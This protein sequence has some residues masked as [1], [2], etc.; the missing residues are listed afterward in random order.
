[1]QRVEVNCISSQWLKV[2]HGVPQGSI[3]G[4]LLFLIYINDLP[5]HCKH[6]QVLLFADDTNLTFLN[7]SCE[8]VQREIDNVKH[9]LDANKLCLNINKTIQLNL[10]S[11]ENRF[12][13]D[14]K[15]ISIEPVCKYLGILV[16]FKFSFVSHLSVL[17]SRLSKQCGIIS[18]LR[19]YSPRNQ[20][21]DYYKTNVSS[22]IQYGILVYGCSSYS[23]LLPI[24]NLLKKI[25]RLIYFRKKSDSAN[26][27]FVKNNL[28]NIYQLHIYELLKLVLKSLSGLHRESYLNSLFSFSPSRPTRSASKTL[29]MEPSCKR[30]IEKRSVKFRASKLFNTLSK[31]D[32]LPYNIIGSNEKVI[33]SFYHKFKDTFLV[34]NDDIVKYIFE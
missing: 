5:L 26:D 22:I 8:E 31:A 16:D 6:A 1:M 32:V 23:N 34:N 20:L 19:H 7:K 33:K 4:P 2:Q 14:N 17:K 13:I 28:L 27:I 15:Y 30:M 12:D 25:L 24:Y 29:L 11:S 18:K 9:W 3:L 21:I 10:K